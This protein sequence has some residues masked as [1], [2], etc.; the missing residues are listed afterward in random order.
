GALPPYGGP[1]V[2]GGTV[3]PSTALAALATATERVRLA[4]LV[5]CAPFR[6]PAHVAKMSTAIDLISGGR[7]DLGIGAGWYEREFEPFGYRYPSTGERFDLL[8]ESVAV[9]AGLFG[10]GPLDHQGPSFRR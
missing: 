2:P 3:D 10:G 5:A 7:F 4:T 8:E 1:Y 6:H 9:M